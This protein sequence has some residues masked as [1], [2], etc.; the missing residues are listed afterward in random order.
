MI[1]FAATLS[2]LFTEYPMRERFRKAGERGF[3][4]VEVLYPYAEAPAERFREWLRDAGTEAVLLNSFPGD[5]PGGRGFAA[6]PGREEDF[7]HSL[8]HT[9]AYALAL[10][11]KRIHII[12]GKVD[13]LDLEECSR[14]QRANLAWAAGEVKKHGLT[15]LLEPLNPTD[16]PGYFLNSMDQALAILTGLNLDNAGFQFDTYHLSMMGLDIQD[17]LRKALP[18]TRHVQVSDCPGRHEPGT[19]TLDFPAFFAALETHGYTGWVGC[20]YIPA[21]TTEEGLGWLD[22]YR[23]AR[24]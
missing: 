21:A 17:A 24:D 8:D 22:R 2:C 14:V 11:A 12:N 18:W 10:G 15:L 16:F 7:R 19:G 20:E 1:R 4:G 6:L 9:L 5:S 3:T 23:D 13:G